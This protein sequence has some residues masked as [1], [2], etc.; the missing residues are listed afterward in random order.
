[1][2]T[3]TIAPQIIADEELHGA[4]GGCIPLLVMS[5]V[6]TVAGTAFMCSYG[7]P[8]PGFSNME[9]IIPYYASKLAANA[10]KEASN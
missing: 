8:A 10:V 4:L 1:M 7:R 2:A 3:Q 5:G 6:T 9:S